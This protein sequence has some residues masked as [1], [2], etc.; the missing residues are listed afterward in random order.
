MKLDNLNEKYSKMDLRRE[1]MEDELKEKQRK[2]EG[3]EL[4]SRRLP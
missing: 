4:V 3:Q 1:K 2:L